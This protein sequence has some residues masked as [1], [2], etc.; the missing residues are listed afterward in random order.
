M[1]ANDGVEQP[2][3]ELLA[4]VRVVCLPAK[5]VGVEAEAAPVIEDS[6]LEQPPIFEEASGLAD[7]F[8]T[9]RAA[10]LLDEPE[11]AFAFDLHHSSSFQ[12]DAVPNQ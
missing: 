10:K 8:T 6:P 1:V 3:G 5:V 4:I 9:D 12:Q 7:R 2:G 11:A